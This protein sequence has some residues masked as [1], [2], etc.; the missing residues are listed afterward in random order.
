MQNNILKTEATVAVQSL[1]RNTTEMFLQETF[2]T[3]PY[4]LTKAAYQMNPIVLIMS[5]LKIL[6]STAS[7]LFSC[8]L[9]YRGLFLTCHPVEGGIF[10]FVTIKAYCH[11][12]LTHIKGKPHTPWNLRASPVQLSD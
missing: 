1:S 7:M 5:S 6:S 3:V 2:D 4:A 8:C 12:A 10:W 11:S 9:F